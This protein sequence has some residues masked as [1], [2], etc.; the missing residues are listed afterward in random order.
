MPQINFNQLHKAKRKSGLTYGDLAKL[1]GLGV[2]RIKS[3]ML[4]H[5][6]LNQSDAR[7]IMFAIKQ[8]A[9]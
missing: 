7:R 9:L 8:H 5:R 4:H 2:G 1:T 6:A 3:Q